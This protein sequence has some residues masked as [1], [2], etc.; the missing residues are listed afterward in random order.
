MSDCQPGTPKQDDMSHSAA[1]YMSGIEYQPVEPVS[2][3][4]LAESPPPASDCALRPR[5]HVCLKAP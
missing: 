3:P 5:N 2:L 4:G 1:K